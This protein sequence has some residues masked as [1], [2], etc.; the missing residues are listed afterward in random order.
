M[1]FTN[2]NAAI[3]EARYL[4]ATEKHHHCVIQ[5]RDGTMRV[6]QEMSTTRE[7]LRK[8]KYTQHGKIDSEL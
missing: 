5:K 6:S 1:M 8:K 2:I 3:E 4:R 7:R